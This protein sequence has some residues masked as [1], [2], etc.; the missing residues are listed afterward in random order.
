LGDLF[1]FAPDVPVF[2]LTEAKMLA[3]NSLHFG[4]LVQEI[5]E[6]GPLL[7]VDQQKSF[8]RLRASGPAI[9]RGVCQV[10]EAPDN[11]GL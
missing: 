8:V 2:A 4:V 3:F 6:G 10:G 5:A 1:V 7:G 9:R 11:S